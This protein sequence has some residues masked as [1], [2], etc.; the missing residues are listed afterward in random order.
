[1]TEYDNNILNN[2][3]NSDLSNSNQIKKLNLQEKRKMKYK[4]KRIQ[5]LEEKSKI[6]KDK[7]AK[8]NII[9]KLIEELFDTVKE[10][11]IAQ[12]KRTIKISKNY[13]L[14]YEISKN[15]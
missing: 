1:M 12:D 10:S 9:K 7:K 4:E 2:I 11:T 3:I 13:T 14:Y 6:Y 5:I 15:K 8:N